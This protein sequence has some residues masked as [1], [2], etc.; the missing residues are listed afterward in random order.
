MPTAT[1]MSRGVDC[2]DSRPDIHPE[3]TELCDADATDEDCNGLAEDADP[4]VQGQLTGFADLDADSYGDDGAPSLHCTLPPGQAPWGGDCDDQRAEIHPGATEV[5]DAVATDEDCDGRS[6]DADPGVDPTTFQTGH[7]DAEGD[8]LGDS[9]A[10]TSACILPAELLA[11]G[12]ACDD[13]DPERSPLAI[14]A[15]DGL[16][17]DCDG[18]TDCADSGTLRFVEITSNPALANLDG[19]QGLTEVTEWLTVRNNSSLANLDGLNNLQDVSYNL[20]I[21]YNTGLVSLHGL[22][23]L[24]AV[25]ATLTL[26]GNG[27][28]TDLTALGALA[29]VGGDLAITQEDSLTDLD[30]LQG[31]TQIAGNLQLNDNA[32][33]IG[34]DGLNSV[35]RVGGALEL[36]DDPLLADVDGLAALQ[37]VA[38]SLAIGGVLGDCSGGC[39]LTT[40]NPSL[41][42]LG[43]LGSLTHV[44]GDFQL[45]SNPL[46]PDLDGLHALTGVGGSLWVVDNPSLTSMTGLDSL[47]SVGGSVT[48]GYGALQVE[49]GYFEVGNT[50]LGSLDGLDTLSTIGGDLMLWNNDA[51]ADVNGLGALSRVNG[52]LYVVGNDSLPNLR[53]LEALGSVGGSVYIGYEPEGDIYGYAVGNNRL[54]SLTGLQGLTTIGGSLW[55][56]D[57]A[58]L[59]DLR[60]LYPLSALGQDLSILNNLS[61]PTSEAEAL[62]LEIEQ[63]GGTSTIAGNL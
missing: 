35:Q 16:D 45:V 27:G 44:G 39:W 58:L 46:L 51:L 47:G 34:L 62:L 10:S 5:C 57:N 50:A 17:N 15:V 29:N 43:G 2:D 7:P 19:L 30:G 55:I 48:I 12:S 60:D 41:Q 40:G 4:G 23:A 33:L 28:L 9:I 24:T 18:L 52:S 14:E 36:M 63:I 42:S 61:L 6:D 26:S 31:L 56:H 32:G 3:A 13:Q 37:E 1:A 21:T 38:G 53:G 11:D 59:T 8:G 20:T 25:G 22:E 54:E 49:Y